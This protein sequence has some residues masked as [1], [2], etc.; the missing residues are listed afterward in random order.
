MSQK[1]VIST[2]RVFAKTDKVLEFEKAVSAHY[3]KYH[4]GEWSARIFEIVSGPDAGGYQISE[5]PNSWEGID[6]RGNLGTEHTID[7]NKNVAINLTE[8]GSMGYYT[9]HDINTY[10]LKNNFKK[11][12]R[13]KMF[14]RKSFEYIYEN[15][16][17]QK[18]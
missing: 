13:L 12:Y 16:K 6:S 7:W 15:S 8:R 17:Y 4:T 11:I 14:F 18:N 9:F 10:L 3:Q 1:N 5:S 2:N